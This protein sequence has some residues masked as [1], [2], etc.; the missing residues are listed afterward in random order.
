MTFSRDVPV[1]P[2]RLSQYSGGLSARLLHV[3]EYFAPD[4][5]DSAL[6][7][8]LD[9]LT[10][11]L[12][13]EEQA[14]LELRIYGRYS[15]TEIARQM[16]WCYGNPPTVDRKKAYR[17]VKRALDKLRAMIGDREWIASLSLRPEVLEVD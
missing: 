8:V 16:E 7:L 11:Q 2:Q 14:C 6:S 13:E 5:Q 9:S 17:A 10:Q 15:Y 3:D 1:D 4:P 12:S